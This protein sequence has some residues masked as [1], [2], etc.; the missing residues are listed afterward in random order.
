M[1]VLF[2]EGDQEPVSGVVVATDL[3][4]DDGRI[5]V[6]APLLVSRTIHLRCCGDPDGPTLVCDSAYSYHQ[7]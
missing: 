1:E 6:P 2:A 3:V 5:P 4:G 7:S